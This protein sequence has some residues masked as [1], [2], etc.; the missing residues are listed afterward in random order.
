M[1]FPRDSTRLKSGLGV[2][3]LPS[4]V[5]HA[6][7]PN[8]ATH[9][10]ITQ[11]DRSKQVELPP[12]PEPV[13]TMAL[14]RERV[15]VSEAATVQLQLEL[16]STKRTLT[17]ARA[18]C[19]PRV[20]QLRE[21]TKELREDL[22]E[23][24]AAARSIARAPWLDKAMGTSLSVFLPL[25]RSRF[26]SLVSFPC[27]LCVGVS[28]SCLLRAGGE[29]GGVVSRMLGS[30]CGGGVVACVGVLRFQRVLRAQNVLRRAR[31]ENRWCG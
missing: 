8:P 7:P 24:S 25:F 17:A 23:A 28:F 26:S 16:A 11:A 29:C 2:R 5:S 27:V 18:L 19:G 10:A 20:R 31:K 6:P 21:Q 22:R 9:A 30:T 4:P 3:P 14:L 15:T 12:P 1:V 13:A